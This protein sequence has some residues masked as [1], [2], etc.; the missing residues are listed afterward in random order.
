MRFGLVIYGTLD[1]VSGGYLY[2]RLLVNHLIA[3]GHEVELI[4]LPWRSYPHHL[5]DNFRRQLANRLRDLSIDLLLQDELNHPSLV[6]VNQRLRG[7]VSYPIVSIVHHLRCSEDHPRVWRQIYRQVE[8]GYLQSVDSFIFN[9]HTTKAT[10][11]TLLGEPVSGIVAYPAADHVDP[12]PTELVLAQ[13]AIKD[14]ESGP[15]QILFVG[16]VI[17]RKGL[18]MLLTALARLPEASWRLYV[19][20]NLLIDP[21]YVKKVRHLIERYGMKT[22]VLLAGSISDD[23]LRQFWDRCHLLVVPSYEGFGIVYLEAMG[24]GLPVIASST[25][26]AHEIVTDGVDGY[27]VDPNDIDDLGQRI[28][29]LHNDRRSLLEMSLAARR[30]YDDHPTWQENSQRIISWLT[31]SVVTYHDRI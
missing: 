28:F 20:G 27:L 11:E 12:P 15:L 18:H 24:F 14:V 13:R 21:A 25:G 3:S 2:D 4:S 10:V 23:E 30:R 29:D 6:R 17:S 9:S 16:N 26:A 8:R 7:R 19:V 5:G 22:S 1:T 31:E